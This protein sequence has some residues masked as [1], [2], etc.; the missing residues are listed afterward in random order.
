MITPIMNNI[1][2]PTTV[3]TVFGVGEA[4]G[5]M[6]HQ[7]VAD[8]GDDDAGDDRQMQIGKASRASWPGSPGRWE[9]ARRSPPRHGGNRSTTSRCWPRSP[10]GKAPTVPT[11]HAVSAKVA[12]VM[13]IDSP[14]AMMRKQPAALG[15]M[16]ALDIPVGEPGMRQD[17]ASRTAPTARDIR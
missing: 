4:F 13:R 17:P 1:G 16:G 11:P 7:L 12:P 15:E 2:P 3:I 6:Q 10:T 5:M 14:S 9:C 8:R